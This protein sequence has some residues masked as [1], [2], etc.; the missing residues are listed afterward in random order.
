M[1]TFNVVVSDPDSGHSV[2]RE[3]DGQ[4]ANRFMGREIGEEIDGSA[5][6]LDGFTVEITGG[7]DAAGRPLRSDVK[8][9]EL[10]ELLLT[11]GTG[12]NPDR[13]G[14]RRRVTVR[15]RE[16]SGEVAQINV[17][18]AGGEGDPLVALGVKEPEED[19]EDEDEESGEEDAEEEEAEPEEDAEEAEP[20][21]DEEE[22]EPD[23]DE[24]DEEE[25]DSEPD[26]EEEDDADESDAEADSEA[27]DD[28]DDADDDGDT[29]DDTEEE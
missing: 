21:E 6:G 11:G 29:D 17:A 5:V 9:T 25:A 10:K 23:E 26:E 1:A 3:V 28:A 24:E 18:I 15:G 8:G 20:D 19:E 4:D 27:D 22:A 12:Y 13:E 14:E 7:S 2:P 16:I